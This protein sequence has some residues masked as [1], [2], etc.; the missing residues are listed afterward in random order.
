MRA[1]RVSAALLIP[2]LIGV[3]AEAADYVEVRREATVYAEP[4]KRSG[5]LAEVAPGEPGSPR[6]LELA[7]T[8]RTRGYYKVHLPGTGAGWIYKTY[9]RRHP[10]PAPRYVPYRRSL[11]QHWI[12]ADRDCQDTRQEVLI[13]EATG[14]VSFDGPRDCGVRRGRWQDPYTGR[15]FRE[16]RQLDIDHLVPLKNAHE[17]GAWAWSAE[18]RRDYANSLTDRRHLLAVK[19]SENRKKGSKGPDE[20]LPPDPAFRCDYVRAWVAIKREWDL[21]MTAAERQAVNALGR[22]CGG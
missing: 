15:I 7:T 22:E 19:A 13:R 20:Y 21:S 8:T 3:T 11:Y 14:R 10:G 9:V 12:D 17:S 6:L 18:R 1:R 16:P 4:L 5:A 2:L